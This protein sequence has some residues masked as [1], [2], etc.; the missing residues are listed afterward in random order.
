MVNPSFFTITSLKLSTMGA[1][2]TPA[3]KDRAGCIP[4]CMLD[5]E[6]IL[7]WLYSYLHAGFVVPVEKVSRLQS[8]IAS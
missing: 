6:E 3:V 2:C 1:A 7:A 4:K 8:S 5:L